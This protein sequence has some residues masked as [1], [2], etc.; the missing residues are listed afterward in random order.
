MQLSLTNRTPL[1]PNIPHQRLPLRR[2]QTI[3]RLLPINPSLRHKPR[4]RLRS[5]QH[6]H[7][8]PLP[9]LQLHINNPIQPL[10][11]LLLLDF[12]YR[13]IEFDLGVGGSIQ[14]DFLLFVGGVV[15]DFGVLALADDDLLEFAVFELDGYV[16]VRDAHGVGTV[17]G[18]D[19]GEFVGGEV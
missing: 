8:L 19:V 16:G 6:L 9:H 2:K 17:G 7:L 18:G 11:P 3:H 4:P 1:I 12:S 13:L 14:R 15:A 5:T 10:L